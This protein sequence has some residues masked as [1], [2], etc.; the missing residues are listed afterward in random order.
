MDGL[1]TLIAEVGSRYAS[2]EASQVQM[3]ADWLLRAFRE[4]PLEFNKGLVEKGVDRVR[5]GWGGGG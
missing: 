3:V 1:L 5:P 4:A 2:S